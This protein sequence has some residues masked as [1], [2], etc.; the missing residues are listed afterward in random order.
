MTKILL[1]SNVVI[2][3]LNPN[4]NFAHDAK[5]IFMLIGD[6]ELSAYICANSLT[7]IYYILKK[8]QGTSNAKTTIENLLKAL[9]ILPLTEADCKEALALPMNDFE[10]AII[11]TCA[12][13]ASIDYI[14]SRDNDFIKAETAVSVIAPKQLLERI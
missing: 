6:N 12:K 4:S 3:A 7:D 9:N 13:K 11:A 5:A 2:D 14:I 10:D 8:I 1:D